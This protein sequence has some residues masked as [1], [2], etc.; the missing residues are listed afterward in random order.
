MYLLNFTLCT[1]IPHSLNKQ[2]AF[3][4][5]RRLGRTDRQ[6]LQLSREEATVVTWTRVVEVEG[7]VDHVRRHD[8]KE[9]R[10][11]TEHGGEGVGSSKDDSWNW[12]I[13]W[14]DEVR[15]ERLDEQV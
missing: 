4:E 6:S 8:D 12:L 13:R 14:M 3:T 5:W 7:E 1:C 10:G 9:S 11:R 15:W 2:V